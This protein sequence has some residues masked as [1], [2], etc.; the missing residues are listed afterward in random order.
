MNGPF[1]HTG[2]SVHDQVWGWIELNF[3]H[4]IMAFMNTTLSVIILCTTVIVRMHNP[5]TRPWLPIPSIFSYWGSLMLLLSSS[6]C[7]P[8]RSLLLQIMVN[9]THHTTNVFRPIP[10]KLSGTKVHQ[11]WMNENKLSFCVKVIN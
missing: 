3:I 2:I 9:R 6:L 8:L 5:T 10:L 7:H 4:T 1:G 11:W